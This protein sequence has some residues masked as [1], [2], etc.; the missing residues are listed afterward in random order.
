MPEG[1][2]SG[3]EV[4]LQPALNP[5]FPW[6]RTLLPET[7]YVFCFVHFEDFKCIG[8]CD[9]VNLLIDDN[10][11][12]ASLRYDSHVKASLVQCQPSRTC[13]VAMVEVLAFGHLKGCFKSNIQMLVL[14]LNATY[15]DPAAPGLPDLHS[16]DRHLR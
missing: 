4:L 10:V 3:F 15:I 14:I 9:T 13:F 16:L 2:G 1:R 5:A 12:S 7:M 6:P 11:E 8:T